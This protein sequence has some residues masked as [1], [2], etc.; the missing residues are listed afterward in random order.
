MPYIE[1]TPERGAIG[2]NA[3]FADIASFALV[4]GVPFGAL[5]YP[6]I[7]DYIRNK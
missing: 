3:M 5:L 2:E 4:F 6:A 7:E 1:S